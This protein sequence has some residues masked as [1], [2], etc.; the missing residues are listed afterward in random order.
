MPL[1]SGS[2]PSSVYRI[3]LT[4]EPG[5]SSADSVTSAALVVQPPGQGP[6]SQAIVVVGA[7]AS[8]VT[9]NGVAAESRPAPLR[10]TT[11]FGSAGSAADASNVYAWAYGALAS[12]P[13][14]VQFAPSA[15]KAT[16]CTP[17]PPSAVVA[18]TV[19]PPVEPGRKKTVEPVALAFVNEPKE[20]FGRARGGG[21][22]PDELR[23]RVEVADLVERGPAH[24]RGRRHVEGAGVRRPADRVAAVERVPE[25]RDAGAAVARGEGHADRGGR[26]PAGRA[27][28]AVAG[29]RARRRGRVLHER[30]GAAAREAGAVVRRHRLR[31]G[32]G[33]RGRPGVRA[34][35][36]G[37]GVVAAARHPGERRERDLVDAGLRVRRRRV[38]GEGAAVRS[39]SGCRRASSR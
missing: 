11:S 32:R 33:R 6:P 5:P 22:D 3:S 1:A 28:G 2:L 34:V 12:L 30:E 26:V 9:V 31:A 17:E 38:D 35:E 13:P 18:V 10:A 14:P 25:R 19:K 23:A 24:G 21:V 16:C 29:D 7:V 20:R 39:R 27:G 36:G 15:G 4:P 8:A 37:G